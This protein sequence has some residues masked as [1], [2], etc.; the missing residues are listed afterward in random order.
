MAQL[1]ALISPAFVASIHTGRTP[2]QWK[3][4]LHLSLLV[5]HHLKHLPHVL[6]FA[7][8]YRTQRKLSNFT[9][10]QMCETFTIMAKLGH[11]P[12]PEWMAAM[13]NVMKVQRHRMGVTSL[14]QLLSGAANIRAAGRLGVWKCCERGGEANTGSSNG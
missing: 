5:L 11:Q 7:C 14:Q 8:V 4:S 3:Q 10:S 6:C 2:H 9:Y 13:A 1:N 12:T